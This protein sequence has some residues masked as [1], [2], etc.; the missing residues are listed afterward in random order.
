M[1]NSFNKKIKK[2]ILLKLSYKKNLMHFKREMV[3]FFP[4]KQGTKN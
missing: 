4:Q 3:N 2:K 1:D